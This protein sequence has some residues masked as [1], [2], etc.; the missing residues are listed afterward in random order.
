MAELYWRGH[1]FRGLTT[2]VAK[3]QTLIASAFILVARRI[4]PL[5]DIRTACT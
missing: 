3:H 4:D 5:R 2:G 1:E